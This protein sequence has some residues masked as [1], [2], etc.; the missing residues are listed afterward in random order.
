MVAV[1]A[2]DVMDKLL[3]CGATDPIP[4][5]EVLDSLIY[6]NPQSLEASASTGKQIDQIWTASRDK[7]T[8]QVWDTR[9]NIRIRVAPDAHQDVCMKTI[10]DIAVKAIIDELRRDSP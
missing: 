2:Q 10:A 1:K 6:R 3:H 4:D 7:V 5:S 8:V 9:A